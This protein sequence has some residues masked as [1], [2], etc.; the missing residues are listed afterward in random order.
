MRKR[1]VEVRTRAYS[2]PDGGAPQMLMEC[3]LLPKGGANWKAAQDLAREFRTDKRLGPH[4]VRIEVGR[5]KVAVYFR[6]SLELMRA[7][8]HFPNSVPG[9]DDPAQLPLFNLKGAT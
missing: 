9:T 3:F 7:V 4:V 8:W 5:S 2:P 6:V 1:R